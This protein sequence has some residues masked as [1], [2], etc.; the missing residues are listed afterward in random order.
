MYGELVGQDGVGGTEI[1]ALDGV[2]VEIALREAHEYLGVV[3]S[4]GE[5]DTVLG[6]FIHDVHI[7]AGVIEEDVL[8]L[9]RGVALILEGL[10]VDD[11]DTFLGY[12]LADIVELA[13]ALLGV[14]LFLAA[15]GEGGYR[16]R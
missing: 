3:A 13:L 11:A 8:I 12:K 5:L 16:Q 6:T 14:G 2:A 4:L 7:D 9:L 1:G 15:R 10:L